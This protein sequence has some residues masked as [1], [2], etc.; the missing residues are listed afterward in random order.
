[1]H[2]HGSGTYAKDKYSSTLA[3]YRH[4]LLSAAINFDTLVFAAPAL[5]TAE[6]SHALLASKAHPSILQ[7]VARLQWPAIIITGSYL[8]TYACAGCVCVHHWQLCPWCCH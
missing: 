6:C 3:A 4:I 5:G 7:R 8:C 1:M 2:S